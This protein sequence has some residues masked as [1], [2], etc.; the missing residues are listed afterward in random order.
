MPQQA[1]PAKPAITQE[2]IDD[3]ASA[4]KI[5][6][7]TMMMSSDTIFYTTILF[8]L[9]QIIDDTVPTAAVD[10]K[11]LWINPIF[12]NDL[13]PGERITLLAHEVLH[14]ALDH[15]HRISDRDPK[16]WNS[17]GDYVIN[18][19][20]VKAGY[21]LP[22]G[23]LHDT[24]YNNKTTEQVYDIIYKKN[25]KE[26][27]DILKKL[28]TGDVIYPDTS[29]PDHVTQDQ[30]T[31]IVLRASTQAKQMGKSIG[32]VPSEVSV[33]LKEI[34]NPPLPW[35][36]ILANYMTEFAK[37]DYTFRR[38]NRRF[39]PNHYLPTAHSEAIANIAVAVDISSSVSDHEFNV[40]I[41][42]IAEIQQAM[43]P[44]KITVISF[45]TKIT[46]V[47]E[48]TDDDNPF[49]QLKFNGR[50]GTAIGPVHEWAKENKPTVLLVFSDGEFQQ[51]EPLDKNVPIVWIINDNPH[52][53]SLHGGRV[54]HYNIIK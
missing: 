50:G 53:N 23:G 12:F 51:P 15:M 52:W 20:L 1:P 45:N 38:P 13:S 11:R 47:Q 28:G 6:K 33:Q 7:I 42:K 44:K 54:I 27:E 43:H 29:D 9:K 3:A 35:H 2:M 48:L 32:S 36:V 17:A 26:Q 34:L 19:M 10:G 39:L 14:V 8:S 21:V 16:L 25:K 37:D 40:F 41:T 4:L 30:V 49:K 31:E 22:D 18:G 24:K 5:A 46:G